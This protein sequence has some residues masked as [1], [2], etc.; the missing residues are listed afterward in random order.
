MKDEKSQEKAVANRRNFL[1]LA[2]LGTAGAV[3]SA[4]T[5]VTASGRARERRP[6]VWLVPRN[7]L[8][9]ARVRAFTLLAAGGHLAPGDNVKRGHSRAGAPRP[10]TCHLRAVQKSARACK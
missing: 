3:A 4:A 5:A 1:K 2:G 7:R 10:G 8:R 6:R 9:Q